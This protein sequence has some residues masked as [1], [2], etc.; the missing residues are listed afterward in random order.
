MVKNRK[1][2][3]PDIFAAIFLI[4]LYTFT[5]VVVEFPIAL[6][7][8]NNDTDI[9]HNQSIQLPLFLI[10]TLFILWFGYKR[11]GFQ[12]KSIFP[13][14]KFPLT[15]VIPMLISLVSIQYLITFPVQWVLS[16][17]PPPDWFMDLLKPIFEN[18]DNSYSGLIKVAI[19]API[20]EEFIFRGMLM[21]GFVLNYGKIRAVLFSAI[22]FSLFHMNPW[23]LPATL[24]LGIIA[25]I[26]RVQSGSLLYAIIVHAIHNSFVYFIV[27]YNAEVT[28]STL[29][30]I[31]TNN[32]VIY[33]ILFVV[34]TVALIY[35]AKKR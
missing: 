13:I 8:Y 28:E 22:L 29:L 4:A 20:V 1:Q 9:S 21:K 12:A 34:S 30:D 7:D 11:S 33:S 5:Q 16:T 6:Y 17:L 14:T 19:V 18:A 32:T 2:Y 26:V 3:Y 27:K 31:S 24:V 23:Q 35:T 15:S 10:T 25:G